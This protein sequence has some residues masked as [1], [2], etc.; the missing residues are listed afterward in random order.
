MNCHDIEERFADRYDGELGSDELERFE[1][2][3]QRCENCRAD[4]ESYCGA[5]EALQGRGTAETSP[6]LRAELLAAVDLAGR[7]EDSR[8]RPIVPLL[9]GI[10][11]GAA[12]AVLLLVFV[13]GLRP[14]ETVPEVIERTVEVPVEVVRIERVEVPV[15]VVR[16]ERVEVPVEIV[17]TERVEVPVEVVV[18]RGP[19]VAIDP[20]PILAAVDR[21]AARLAEGVVGFGREVGNGLAR[22]GAANR[23]LETQRPASRRRVPLRLSSPAAGIASAQGEVR[24]RELGGRVRI[25]TSGALSEYVPVLIGQLDTASPAVR[26]AIEDRLASV[27]ARASEDPELR[28]QL[29]DP[30]PGGP[31]EVADAGSIFRNGRRRPRIVEETSAERWSAWWDGNERLLVAAAFE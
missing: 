20:I 16:T 27:H 12:A 21:L 28:G 13:P 22:S 9:F 10:A 26:T 31:R 2:H 30:R 11:V 29:I 3:L 6:E 1:S 15:E 8:R 19:L 14:V 25:E 4:W 7:D 24:I 17:R 5:I 23:A 18:P